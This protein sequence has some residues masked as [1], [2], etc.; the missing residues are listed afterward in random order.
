MLSPPSLEVAAQKLEAGQR[1]ALASESE[2][3][4]PPPY[5]E[6]VAAQK[7]EVEA[8][9]QKSSQAVDLQAWQAKGVAKNRVVDS[10][11][12]ATVGEFLILLVW[13]CFWLTSTGSG[14]QPAPLQLEL[15]GSNQPCSWNWRAFHCSTGCKIR[16][17]LPG[18]QDSCTLS[19]K[20][21]A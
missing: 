19:V 5:Q 7:L 2:V 11:P 1:R 8:A 6:E 13:L 18:L 16:K 10:H 12:L 17:H 9:P 3:V 4:V 21:P 15:G 14:G 20:E